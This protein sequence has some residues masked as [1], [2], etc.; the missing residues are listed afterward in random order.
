MLNPDTY[1]LY[2]G[3]PTTVLTASAQTPIDDLD[4]ML[5]AT[6]LADV[7][8]FTGGTS[9]QLLGQVTLDGG[10]TWLDAVNFFFTG[11]GKKFATMSGTAET[12]IA[13]YVALTAGA[14][15]K[16]AGLMGPEYRAVITTIGVFSSMAA[17]LRLVAR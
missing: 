10:T 9:I 6:F 7:V 11:A 14:D 16:N 15:G 8:G 12:A 1:T 4:G 3:S 5:A 17:S 2:A 13:S